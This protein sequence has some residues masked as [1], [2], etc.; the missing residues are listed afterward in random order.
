[1]YIIYPIYTIEVYHKNTTKIPTKTPDTRV[2]H[3]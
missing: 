3:A 2:N 1:M